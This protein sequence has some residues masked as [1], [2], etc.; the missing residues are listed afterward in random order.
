[1]KKKGSDLTDNEL[2]SDLVDILMDQ[3]Q[4]EETAFL[5]FVERGY[6][7]N[8]LGFDFENTPDEADSWGAMLSVK[9]EFDMYTAEQLSSMLKRYDPDLAFDGGAFQNLLDAD[10]DQMGLGL[11]SEGKAVMGFGTKK[12]ADDDDPSQFQFEMENLDKPEGGEM[13]IPKYKVF[14]G[15]VTGYQSASYYILALNADSADDIEQAGNVYDHMDEPSDPDWDHGGNQLEDV[16]AEVALTEEM[17]E[18]TL[19]GSENVAGGFIDSRDIR[20]TGRY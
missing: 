6:S 19:E 20:Y 5:L 11:D 10:T 4:W 7:L 13:T 14:R 9:T 16:T 12:E 18:E 15:D 1:M 3:G 17:I 8:Q 2:A